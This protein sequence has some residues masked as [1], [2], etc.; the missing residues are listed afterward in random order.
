MLKDTCNRKLTNFTARCQLHLRGLKYSPC[1]L[2]STSTAH[3]L[4]PS[5]RELSHSPQLLYLTGLL[6]G[7]LMDVDYLKIKKNMKNNVFF[8]IQL[9]HTPAGIIACRAQWLCSL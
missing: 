4:D 6:C 2:N 1:S 9:R 3:S 8:S 7:G 5:S